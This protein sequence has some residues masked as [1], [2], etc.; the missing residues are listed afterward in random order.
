MTDDD[1]LTGQPTSASADDVSLD[2]RLAEMRKREA[3]QMPSWF[4]P[5]LGGA[6]VWVVTGLWLQHKINWP[7]S[8]GFPH[9]CGV[10]GFRGC[11]AVDL[12][13]SSALLERPTGYSLAL[14]AWYISMAAA[15]VWILVHAVRRTPRAKYLLSLAMLAAC[16][17]Y[18]ATDPAFQRATWNS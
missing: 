6:I 2:E 18:L 17:G 8:Y 9:T 10:Y 5:L 4:L 16:V 11:W 13:H 1:A 14:F 15:I 12:I 7:D 3:E